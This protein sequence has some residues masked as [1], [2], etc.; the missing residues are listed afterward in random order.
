M[1]PH[2]PTF[3]NGQAGTIVKSAKTNQK[4]YEIATASLITMVVSKPSLKGVVSEVFC[5]SEFKLSVLSK[6]RI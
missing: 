6:G 1:N 2:A 4:N 3:N 5:T